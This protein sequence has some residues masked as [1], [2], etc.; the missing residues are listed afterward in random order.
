[1]DLTFLIGFLVIAVLIFSNGMFVAT[2]FAYVAARRSRL[3]ERADRGDAGARMALSSMG[4][5][6]R[7]VAASQLGITMASL[8]LGFV[9][10]PLFASAIEPPLEELIGTFAPAAAHAIAIGTAFFLIT[11]LH[12]VFGEL[13]PKTI[14]L[15]SPESTATIVSR[16]M[17]VFAFVFG[18]LIALLNGIGNR[19]LGIFGIA[20]APFGHERTLTASDLAYAFES[21][22]SVGVLSRRE[23]RLGQRA[24]ELGQVTVRS[25]MIPRAEVISADT[26]WDRDE[27]RRTVGR[28][29]RSRYPVVSGG[30]DQVA[31]LLDAKRVLLDP[32]AI[33]WRAHLRPI[34]Y[35]PDSTVLGRAI[36]VLT[37]DDAGIA[38][39]VDEYGN[40]DGLVALADVMEYLAGPLS[41]ERGEADMPVR[42]LGEGRYAVDGVLRLSEAARA[43]LEL[44]GG[45]T[46]AD[47]VGGLVIER[48][49]RLPEVGDEI[50]VG[51]HRLRVLAVEDRRIEHLEVALLRANQGVDADA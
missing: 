28:A 39:V 7:Y 36:E 15:Q 4:E 41:D 51:E 20:S 48:L 37:A 18:P 44:Q 13:I 49:Q 16:P 31:G 33:D 5:L 25:L 26:S 29:G 34:P 6:D 3:R 45:E 38:L 47:T 35:L 50:V 30:L 42:R 22:A 14:A 19:I 46:T 8:A 10:E 17:R 1:M 11:S 23:L 40:V 27:V 32:P 2:E 43:P 24:L 21:S 9:G 12:I